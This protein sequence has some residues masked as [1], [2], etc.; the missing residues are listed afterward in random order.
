MKTTGLNFI[1]AVKAA[2]EGHII[3]RDSWCNAVMLISDGTSLVRKGHP[4]YYTPTVDSCLS[5]NWEIVQK[6]MTFMEAIAKMKEGKSTTR[7]GDL[8]L[9]A[10]IDGRDDPSSSGIMVHTERPPVN[11]LRVEDVEATDWITIDTNEEEKE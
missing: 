3:R 2:K 1:E 9:L 8:L 5:D 7:F 6:P 10:Y 4:G 11:R